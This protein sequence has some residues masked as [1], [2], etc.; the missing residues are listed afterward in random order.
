MICCEH[1][2]DTSQSKSGVAEAML[3]EQA[4]RLFGIVET[5]AIEPLIDALA[6]LENAPGKSTRICVH[7][8]LAD[9]HGWFFLGGGARVGVLAAGCRAC[10]MTR[11]AAPAAALA[12]PLAAA[13]ALPLPAALAAGICR[14]RR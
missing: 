10:A 7:A 1:Q 12:L 5:L 8:E 4:P 6:P 2:L 14:N 13:P 9:T 3:D 11:G